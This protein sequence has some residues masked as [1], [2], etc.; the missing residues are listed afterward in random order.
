MA[1]VLALGG[2]AL[3]SWAVS[4]R[5]QSQSYSNDQLKQFRIANQLLKDSRGENPKVYSYPQ[6]HPARLAAC[7]VFEKFIPLLNGAGCEKWCNWPYVDSIM[8]Y[9]LQILSIGDPG[10]YPA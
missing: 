3:V 6:D 9:E 5:T 10:K 4:G 2:I 7:R 1:I 8:D